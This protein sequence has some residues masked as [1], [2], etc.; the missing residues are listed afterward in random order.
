MIYLIKIE[1]ISRRVIESHSLTRTWFFVD[2]PFYS[3][4][5]SPST[6]TISWWQLTTRRT[7][8]DIWCE[9]NISERKKYIFDRLRISE[10]YGKK[11]AGGS[12]ALCN[13]TRGELLEWFEFDWWG[14]SLGG[15]EIEDWREVEGSSIGW[16]NTE[17]SSFWRFDRGLT[18]ISSLGAGLG[19]LK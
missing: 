7:F 11:P 4:S 2:R 10:T 13:E 19:R 14:G 5:T 15:Y 16:S 18:N 1:G 3:R 6:L 9:F 12:M 8:I 17:S